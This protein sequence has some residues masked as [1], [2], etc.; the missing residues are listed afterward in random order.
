MPGNWHVRFGERRAETGR[1]KAARRCAPTLLLR[2]LRPVA[3]T[4]QDGQAGVPEPGAARGKRRAAPRRADACRRGIS[5]P[6]AAR[7]AMR[8]EMPET[9]RAASKAKTAK[10]SRGGGDRDR[11]VCTSERS[12]RGRLG[13]PAS[14]RS[15]GPKKRRTAVKGKSRSNGPVSPR[16]LENSATGPHGIPD[17]HLDEVGD[18]DSRPHRSGQAPT[19]RYLRGEHTK[20]SHTSTSNRRQALALTGRAGRTVR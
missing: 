8:R 19:S 20:R 4:A 1:R 10:R 11:P 17:H 9:T 14:I 15:M 3:M 7:T 5:L 18:A 12:E 16:Y 2:G 6:S 13:M